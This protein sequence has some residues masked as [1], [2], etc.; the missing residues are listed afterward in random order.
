M[1]LHCDVPNRHVPD[2]NCLQFFVNALST[3]NH[4]ESALSATTIHTES[5]ENSPYLLLRNP[6][7]GY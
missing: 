7:F 2:F 4:T 5:A 3:T 1:T 6:K